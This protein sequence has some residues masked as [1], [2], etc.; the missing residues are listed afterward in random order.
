LVAC[1]TKST[2]MPIDSSIVITD[3]ES[4]VHSEIDH[5]GTKRGN[6][7]PHIAALDGLRGI[8][9]LAVMAY[10][11]SLGHLPY[12]GRLFGSGWTGVDLF[13]VLS[14]FLITRILNESKGRHQFFLNFYARR[15]L[16][17][18]PLYFGV[19]IVVFGV[20]PKF[21]SL[22]SLHLNSPGGELPFWLYYSNIAVCLY[23]W[24]AAAMGHF[25]S[26]AI[27]EQFYLVWPLIVWSLSR[28]RLLHFCVAIIAA[29]NLIRVLAVF[30]HVSAV[31]TTYLTPFRIDTLLIGSAA[32]LL[33]R[34]H[35]LI[36]RRF[37]RPVLIGSG[38]ILVWM[39][40]ARSGLSPTDAVVRAAG[41]PLL[42]IFFGSAV[43]SAATGG[44]IFTSAL[45][46]KALT[47]A[48]KYSYGMYVFHQLLKD[49]WDAIF[50]VASIGLLAHAACATAATFGVAYL[51]W[52]LYEVHFIKLKRFF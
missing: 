20:I 6:A 37:A 7:T 32:A 28:R 27:E 3:P 42:G 52:N 13:F 10:H 22:E 36:A 14:G 35:P 24:P 29:V 40:A 18:F 47:H 21:V 23:G 1:D 44:G 19:L 49:V 39:I 25:W 33:V 45:S 8:A 12:A 17:I 43:L 50:P 34:S 5:P 41:Y 31:M 46:L 51:S 30:A 2:E 38:M 26:L 16:R 15:T 4:P 48:G 11:F 9:V